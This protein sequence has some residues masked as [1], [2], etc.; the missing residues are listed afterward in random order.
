MEILRIRRLE[1]L[2]P[3]LPECAR[4]IKDKPQSYSVGADLETQW[5]IQN[6]TNKRSTFWARHGL[7][8]ITSSGV[9]QR[10]VFPLHGPPPPQAVRSFI[11]SSPLQLSTLRSSVLLSRFS[12]LVFPLF[13]PRARVENNEKTPLAGIELG[14]S[15]GRFTKDSCLSSSEVVIRGRQKNIETTLAGIEFGTFFCRFK[16][17]YGRISP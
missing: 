11:R 9:D 16:A 13:P 12:A 3:P 14:T 8:P 4:F 2:T 7:P 17:F 5:S 15:F 1:T 6:A 10:L